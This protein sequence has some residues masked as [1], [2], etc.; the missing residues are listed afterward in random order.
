MTAEGEN[1][2]GG[3]VAVFDEVLGK[4]LAA[5][6]EI[7][8]GKRSTD[9]GRTEVPDYALARNAATGDVGAFE[10]LYRRHVSRVAFTPSVFV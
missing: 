4:T 3:A 7:P 2:T 8:S 6:A 9:A 1:M 5:A 10:Q